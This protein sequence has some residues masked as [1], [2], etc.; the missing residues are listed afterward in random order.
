MIN[1]ILVQYQ[2]TLIANAT[3]GFWGL[4]ILM[5]WQMIGYMMIIYI[6]GL[7]N[8]PLDQ[9]NRSSKNRWCNKYGRLFLK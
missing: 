1:A 9:I 4:V 8:V 5:N 6:A 7:Q 2:T 3:Y